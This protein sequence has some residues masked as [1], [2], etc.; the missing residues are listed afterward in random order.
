MRKSVIIAVLV[1][2]PASFAHAQ[3]PAIAIRQELVPADAQV[4]G[5]WQNGKA[6]VTVRELG[7]GKCYAVGTA[8]G[9]SYLKSAVRMTPWARGGRKMVYNPTDFDEG[10]VKLARLGTDAAEIDRDDMSTGRSNAS[11]DVARPA[12]DVQHGTGGSRCQLIQ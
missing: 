1:L 2:I 5:T 10:A 11:P 12:A 7:K 9:H 6:A 8:A 4:I 3:I